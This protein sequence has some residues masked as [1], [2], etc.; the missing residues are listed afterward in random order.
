MSANSGLSAMVM[1]T[2]TGTLRNAA[3]SVEPSAVV[4]DVAGDER[5]HGDLR[6]HYDVVHVEAFGAVKTFFTR[7]MNGKPRKRLGWRGDMNL[8]RLRR[9]NH[10]ENGQRRHHK[11]KQ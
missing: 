6:P 10:G 8:G 1:T 3:R 5:L 11:A 7:K 9:G 2:R 4:A